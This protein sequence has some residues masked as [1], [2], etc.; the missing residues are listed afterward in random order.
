LGRMSATRQA[1]AAR[2]T[3]VHE[4]VVSAE[5]AIR[6]YRRRR[7]RRRRSETLP[8]CSWPG[9]DGDAPFSGEGK[10]RVGVCSAGVA[11]LTALQSRMAHRRSGLPLHSGS[12]RN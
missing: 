5:R 7:W 6:E 8:L 2:A 4:A 1:S 10:G 3:T 11:V 12:L 9:V